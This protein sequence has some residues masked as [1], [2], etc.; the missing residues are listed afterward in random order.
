MKKEEEGEERGN[1]MNTEMEKR[2]REIL[3]PGQMPPHSALKKYAVSLSR[4]GGGGYFR[5][6]RGPSRNRKKMETRLFF[7]ELHPG[8]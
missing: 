2:G 6:H 4:V 7:K 3:W 8:F 1:K 5:H